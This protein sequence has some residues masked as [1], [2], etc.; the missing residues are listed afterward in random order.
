MNFG[1]AFFV[2]DTITNNYL[3]I[4]IQWEKHWEHETHY[5]YCYFYWIK[6]TKTLFKSL[7][8]RE[9]IPR[10]KR[11]ETQSPKEQKSN[12]SFQYVTKNSTSIH[13]Y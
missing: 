5:I 11:E 3:E 9:F 12:K 2:V 13:I 7:K 6:I 10:Q 1:R 4:K 8:L